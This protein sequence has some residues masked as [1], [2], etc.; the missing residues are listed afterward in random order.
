MIRRVLAPALDEGHASL[1]LD[2]ED[3]NSD[4]PAVVELVPA[5]ADAARLVVAVD[6]P[7]EAYID[8]GNYGT[9]F[10]LWEE[11]G[12][13]F[14]RALAGITEAVARGGY[15]EWVRLGSNGRLVAAKGVFR[16]AA[17]RRRV[18]MHNTLGWLVQHRP[19]WRHV[20]YAP[21]D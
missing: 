16:H 9:H 12:E 7:G 18:V 2:A 13:S 3:A 5:V 19:G 1:T 8:V 11:P 10:E 20:R 14:D 6:R 17:G 21:Y 4:K 15:E